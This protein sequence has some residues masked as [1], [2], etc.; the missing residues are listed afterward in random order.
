[1]KYRLSVILLAMIMM[2]GCIQEG[3]E[4]MNE[5]T[6]VTMT[7]EEMESLKRGTLHFNRYG[8]GESH[9]QNIMRGNFVPAP[10][11]IDLQTIE[12]FV[13]IESIG[14]IGHGLVIDKMHDMLYLY[15]LRDGDGGLFDL[16]HYNTSTQFQPQDLTR[17]IQVIK[18]ADIRNW[19][20]YYEGDLEF[21][22]LGN[23]GHTWNIGILF[24]DGTILRR[25]GLGLVE[26]TDFFPPQDQWD[27]LKDFI[28]AMGE[29][30]QGRHEA[31][32]ATQDE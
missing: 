4:H 11:N 29:E 10:N 32:Q 21:K 1:M 26:N 7:E 18:D 12:R 22:G 23:F 9:L 27:M 28:D 17:L 25:S 16:G 31:E 6:N 15:P 14:F 3:D 2:T 8:I 20:E 30:I 19:Q 5:T 24:S 13:F